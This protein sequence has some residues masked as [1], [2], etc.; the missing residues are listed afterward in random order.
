MT[1]AELWTTTQAANRLNITPG[2]LRSLTAA[3]GIQPAARQPGRQGQNLW[4]PADIDSIPRPGQG[5]RTDL[6]DTP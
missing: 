4:R 5:A 6:Q 2:R 1:T 3:A